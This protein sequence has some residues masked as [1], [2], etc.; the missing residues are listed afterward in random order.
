MASKGNPSALHFM[1]AKEQFSTIWWSKIVDRRDVFASQNHLKPFLKFAND[2]MERL[3]GRKGQKN[4]HR[5]A[6]EQEH[7]YDTKYAMHV[8]RLYLEAKEYMETGIITLPNP[9]VDLLVSIRRGKYG[10][11]EIEKMGQE[12]EAE[13]LTAQKKSVLPEAV[14]FSAVTKLVTDV[15][16]DFWQ[17]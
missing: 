17:R 12:L 7:G 15:Y 3:L 4:V 1:F 13:A 10:Q 16:M 9:R 14:D 5:A 6:L 2:Q 11:F 8:I